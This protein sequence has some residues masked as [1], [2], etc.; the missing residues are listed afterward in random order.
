M[1]QARRS[2]IVSGGASG[3]GKATC[4][5]L[6]RDGFLV[7]VA[8]RDGAGAERVAQAIDGRSHPVDVADEASV[9]A[10]FAYADGA[11]GG[12]LDALVTAAGIAD[13]KPFMEI[14]VATWRR[15]YDVN[16]DRHVPPHPRSGQ[17]HATRRPDLHGGE[18][19]GQTRRRALRNGGVCR[20]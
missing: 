18:R 17:T 4:E 9:A 14:D 5:L 2:A 11:L 10:L 15:V 19:R 3:I 16:V 12:R 8:D 20:E 1:T 7:L 6:A 13:M